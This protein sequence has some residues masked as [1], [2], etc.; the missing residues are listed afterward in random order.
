MSV[1]LQA[2][3]KVESNAFFLEMPWKS[4]SLNPPKLQR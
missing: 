1:G 2:V 4:N 3:M